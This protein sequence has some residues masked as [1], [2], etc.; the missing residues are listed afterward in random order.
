MPLRFGGM[1]FAEFPHMRRAEVWMPEHKDLGMGSEAI[2]D[3]IAGILT[4][5]PEPIEVL[6]RDV[7]SIHIHSSMFLKER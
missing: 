4:D 7:G 3:V 5:I 2:E 1:V 6:E